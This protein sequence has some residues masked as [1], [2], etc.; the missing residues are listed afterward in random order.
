MIADEVRLFL[1]A[2]LLGVGFGLLW[3]VFRAFRLLLP[4][5]GRLNFFLDG[6]FFLVVMAV[7]F[8]FFLSRTYGQLRLFLLIGEGL[9]FLCFWGTI[10]RPV[11]WMTGGIA[12]VIRLI[13]GKIW[14]FICRISG[15]I[16]NKI[17]Q[18]SEISA[19]KPDSEKLT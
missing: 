14:Q 10:G 19:K 7:D 1:A 2:C 3:E 5:G 18:K 9:G 8:L 6:G 16:Q 11:R 12:R 4:A 15:K 17:V 13:T